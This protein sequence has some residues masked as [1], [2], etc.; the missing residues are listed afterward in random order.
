MQVEAILYKTTFN[1]LFYKVD[2]ETSLTNLGDIL[3]MVYEMK[4]FS[5][6]KVAQVSLW[7]SC[8]MAALHSFT[9]VRLPDTIN[10]LALG[11]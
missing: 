3:C 10:V 8:S 7:V 9:G 2:I 4:G 6:Q 5:E 1:I 11:K